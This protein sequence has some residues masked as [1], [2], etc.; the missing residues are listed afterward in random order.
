[1]HFIKPVTIIN[2]YFFT[3]LFP[4][5]DGIEIYI[6]KDVFEIDFDTK[7]CFTAEL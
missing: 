5:K 4:N 6:M 1:M 3:N 2:E 7:F